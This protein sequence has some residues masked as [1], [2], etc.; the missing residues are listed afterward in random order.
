MGVNDKIA[1]EALDWVIRLAEDGFADWDGFDAWLAADPAHG[2]AYWPM[3]EA[4]RRVAAA[5]ASQSAAPVS[6][7]ADHP[8]R[9]WRSVA[10]WS[11][12]ASL[13]ATVA[14]YTVLR[15]TADDRMIVE[16][17]P[18]TTRALSLPDGSRIALNGGTRLVVDRRDPRRVSLDR[19][20]AEFAIRHDSRRPFTLSVGGAEIVDVGTRFNVVRDH[21]ETRVEVANGA[22][23]FERGSL[24]QALTAGQALSVADETGRILLGKV[25]PGFVSGWR[26]HRLAYDRAPLPVVAADLERATGAKID[27]SPDVAGR[28]FT[29]TLST[30][31]PAGEPVTRFAAMM[32]L[33]ATRRGNGW[34]L[35]RR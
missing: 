11:I 8:R 6:H 17:R 27:Y 28:M 23:R 20:E 33:E 25:D 22:V 29:G 14:V 4:D 9:R 21:G 10:G 13:A 15:A 34:I 32:D 19:G 2:E 26:V 16:T 35:S 7:I 24:T 31:G 30:G 3:A 1:R 12:A 5:F 18:G